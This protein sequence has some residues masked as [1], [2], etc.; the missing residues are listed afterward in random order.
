MERGLAAGARGYVLKD[1][2]GEELVVAVH[3]VLAGE[4]VYVSC[5]L[6]GLGGRATDDATKGTA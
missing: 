4:L 1:S 2:A 3:A 5:A 6:G